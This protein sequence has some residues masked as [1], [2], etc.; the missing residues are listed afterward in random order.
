MNINHE[1]ILCIPRIKRDVKQ[2]YIRE[3]FRK[4]G[5]IEHF[6]ESP[7]QKDSEY[8]RVLLKIIW[9]NNNPYIETIKSRLYRDQDFKLVYQ[10]PWYWVVYLSNDKS[11]NYF[12]T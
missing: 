3:S 6:M 4:I 2:E 7:L 10:P 12:Q 5:K 11:N 8:K 1:A 9:D